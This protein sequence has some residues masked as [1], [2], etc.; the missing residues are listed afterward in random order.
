M[1]TP[2]LLIIEDHKDFRKAVRHFLEAHHVRAD[3]M[4][5]CSG[6]EGVLLARKNKPDI[7]VTDFALGGIDGLEVS[8]AD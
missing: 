5:A 4:E 7:V 6:E 3:M 1:K 2:H 8:Q